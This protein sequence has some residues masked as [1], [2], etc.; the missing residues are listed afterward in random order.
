MRRSQ[1]GR[2]EA[3]RLATWRAF[4]LSRAAQPSCGLSLACRPPHSFPPLTITNLFK[5]EYLQRL[6]AHTLHSTHCACMLCGELGARR[7]SCSAKKAAATRRLLAQRCQGAYIE[8]AQ[9]DEGAT[10]SSYPAHHCCWLRLCYGMGT[11]QGSGAGDGGKGAR[12][13]RWVV[14]D[15]RQGS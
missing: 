10:S 4:F 14:S 3:G 7:R 11:R 15:L 13:S 8:L 5:R 12:R 1:G 2:A 9:D 6:N